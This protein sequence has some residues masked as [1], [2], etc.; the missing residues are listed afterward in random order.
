MK[1][2]E[3]VNQVLNAHVPALAAATGMSQAQ[4]Y[5]LMGQHLDEMS[6]EWTKGSQ[7]AIHYSDPFCRLA[8]V[9]AHVGINANLFARALRLPLPASGSPSV[10]CLGDIL[11]ARMQLGGRLKL[12]AFGGGP[13]TE[14]LAMAKYIERSVKPAQPVDV[15]LLLLDRVPEW[16][17]TWVALRDA[18]YN[19]VTPPRP[20]A[21]SSMVIPFDFTSLASYGHL[22][23]LLQRDLFVLNYVVSEVFE[24]QAL[25]NLAT[26][27]AHMT[28]MSPEAPILILDRSDARTLER[29]GRVVQAAALDVVHRDTVGGSMDMDEQSSVLAVH[30]RALG[31]NGRDRAPRVSWMAGPYRSAAAYVMLGKAKAAT[32]I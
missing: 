10:T 31:Q 6:R 9:Y 11:G 1:Y 25:A 16:S 7:P 24:D 19:Q 17:E 32:W 4:V 23:A 15:E 12:A 28:R 21:I 2:F 26:V 13:G 14:L 5:A 8:Y 20:F 29:V 22:T 3:T 30:N 18:I 27:V